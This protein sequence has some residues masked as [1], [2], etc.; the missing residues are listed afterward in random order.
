MTQVHFREMR[1]GRVG[2]DLQDRHLLN[3]GDLHSRF[4]CNSNSLNVSLYFVSYEI[5]D[6]TMNDERGSMHDYVHRTK[7]TTYMIQIREQFK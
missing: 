1:W 5:H 3:R 6:K 2:N 7:K 4:D